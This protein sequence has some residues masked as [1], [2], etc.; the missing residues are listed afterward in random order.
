[1][2]T[3]DL[4]KFTMADF[5]AGITSIWK[6][7]PG[8]GKTAV[9]FKFVDEIRK[10]FPNEN[11]GVGRTF[12]ATQLDVDA[13]GLPSF[14]N[15]EFK[16][17]NY[18]IVQNA[19]PNWYISTDGLPLC[20]YDRAIVIFEEWGQASAETKRAHT[21]IVLEHGVPGFYLPQGSFVLVLTNVDARDG[22]TKEF[23]FTITRWHQYEVTNEV[24][25]W[26][27][28]FAAKPYQYNNRTWHVSPLL[29][30]WAKQRPTHFYEAKPKKQGPYSNART[31]CAWDRWQQALA[32]N[33]PDGLKGLV[34]ENGFVEGSSGVI[35]EPATQSL[36][37]FID[38][39]VNLPSY[40][41]IV[42]DPDNAPVP[43]NVDQKMLLAYALAGWVEPQG[44]DQCF[45]YMKRMAADL[46]IT[47]AQTTI[48]RDHTTFAPLP[49]MRTFISKNA[50]LLTALNSMN[51]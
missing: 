14:G 41:D 48:Q 17:K 22:V 33:H 12:M 10:R 26:D 49:A 50:K 30:A 40:N 29:R 5:D 27:E 4:I 39:H 37:E 34:R 3:R 16:G 47:F 45:T 1:M 21:P 32:A 24:R 28:D 36:L 8:G 20:C 51:K 38:F 6:G 18:R 44:L 2:H 9:S 13:I 11:I 43:A 31:A 25:V 15:A 7:D 46:Q 19:M 23:D 35:G 42:N